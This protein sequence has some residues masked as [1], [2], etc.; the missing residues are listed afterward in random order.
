MVALASDFDVLRSRFLARL[1]TILFAILRHASAWQVRTLLLLI[2]CHHRSPY[3]IVQS[4][5]HRI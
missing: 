4:G 5:S 2:S 3:F 1:A